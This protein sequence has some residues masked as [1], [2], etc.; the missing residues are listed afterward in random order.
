MAAVAWV[1]LGEAG[2][3]PNPPRLGYTWGP[4]LIWDPQFCLMGPGVGLASLWNG[5]GALLQ[6]N[7]LYHFLPQIQN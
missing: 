4:G 6:A 3:F 2:A 5:C 7:H 1:C